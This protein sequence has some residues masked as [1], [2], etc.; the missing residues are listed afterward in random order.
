MSIFKKWVYILVSVDH[1]YA[2]C[3]CECPAGAIW[4]SGRRYCS[5]SRCW[6]KCLAS[7]LIKC[8]WC[9]TPHPHYHINDSFVPVNFQNTADLDEA[10]LWLWSRWGHPLPNQWESVFCWFWRK[11]NWSWWGRWKLG[12]NGSPNIRDFEAGGGEGPRDFAGLRMEEVPSPQ[13][14]VQRQN[15]KVSVR[16][17]FPSL[18]QLSKQCS[19][20]AGQD[21]A[22][23][24]NQV[25][26]R[27]CDHSKTHTR[28]WTYYL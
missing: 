2:F 19:W 22:S 15:V 4:K 14:W 13:N 25:T 3:L 20:K 11:E 8:H 23:W 27:L 18:V 10:Q 21:C 16:L 28:D 26:L 5:F 12:Q 6:A 9:P 1:K 17:E 24:T 7:T